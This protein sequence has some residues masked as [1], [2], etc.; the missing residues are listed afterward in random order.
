MQLRATMQL[1]V[2]VVALTSLCNF[3]C[4]YEHKPKRP[5]LLSTFFE[6]VVAE[7]HCPLC[8]PIKSVIVVI[9]IVTSFSGLINIALFDHTA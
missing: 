4:N 8:L 3:R 5:V 7:L 1:E 9:E 2:A 6:A